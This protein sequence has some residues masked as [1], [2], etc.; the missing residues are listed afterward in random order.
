MGNFQCCLVVLMKRMW[1]EWNLNWPCGRQFQF[2]T[3]I[4]YPNYYLFTS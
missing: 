3:K 2:N 4:Q 1:Q